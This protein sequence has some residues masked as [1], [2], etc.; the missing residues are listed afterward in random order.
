MMCGRG[1][2]H[3]LACSSQAHVILSYLLWSVLVPL[4]DV[5]KSAIAVD[6]HSDSAVLVLE[7]I[8]LF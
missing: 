5:Y 8:S 4:L 1:L 7:H 3:K 2:V 6:D